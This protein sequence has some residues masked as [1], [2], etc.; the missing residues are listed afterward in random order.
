[1][2][3]QRTAFIRPLFLCADVISTMDP[4]SV[5][6]YY[7]P[8]VLFHARVAE[9]DRATMTVILAPFH[10]GKVFSALSAQGRV[11][12]W[13]EMNHVNVMLL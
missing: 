4:K 1:M 8:L 11:A 5:F 2:Y 6:F 12:L 10:R 3:K 9:A 13:E 7:V